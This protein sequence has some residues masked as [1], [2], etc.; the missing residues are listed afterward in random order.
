MHVISLGS[1][2]V[3]SHGAS[4]QVLPPAVVCTWVLDIYLLLVGT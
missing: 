2:G 4:A 3:H 1:T